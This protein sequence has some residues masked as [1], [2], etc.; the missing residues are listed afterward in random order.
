MFET[1]REGEPLMRRN[2][3]CILSTNVFVTQL[4]F[5]S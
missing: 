5:L 1:V 2:L 4:D 3:K